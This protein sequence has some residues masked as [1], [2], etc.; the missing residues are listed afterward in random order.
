MRLPDYSQAGYVEGWAVVDSGL[1]IEHGWVAKDGTVIDPTL[2]EDKIV[3]FPG[4]EFSGRDGI[5]A[6]MA[7]KDGKKCKKTPLFYS[8]GW[9]GSNHA[10]YQQ[11]FQDAKTYSMTFG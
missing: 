5:E 6:F 4:L 8:F 7:T 10:G 2:P 1:L 3:Y 9:G 11:A